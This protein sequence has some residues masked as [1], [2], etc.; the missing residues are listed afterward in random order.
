[1]G[2]L[3][4]ALVVGALFLM[5]S[6]LGIALPANA[7]PGPTPR[8]QYLVA[9]VLWRGVTDAERGFMDYL[10]EHGVPVRFV[11]FNC[12]NDKK[13]LPGY[14]AKVKALH[15]ALVYT[16]G[17]TVTSAVAGREGAVDPKRNITRTPIVFNIVA[18]PVGAG[19][20]RSMRS[21]GRNVTGVTHTVPLKSQ[22][23]TIMQLKAVHRLGVIYDPQEKNSVLAVQHLA[24]LQKTF[25][26]RVL[27]A[28]VHTSRGR[29]AAQSIGAAVQGLA[30]QKPDLIYLPSDSYLIAHANIVTGDINRLGIPS[31]SATEG[32]V[33][34]SGALMG[35]VTRY[36]NAGKFAG[37]KAWEILVKH[38]RPRDIPV[39]GLKRFTV[40]VNMDTARQLN[41]YPPVTLL[42][43]AEVVEKKRQVTTAH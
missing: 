32:P 18:D 41:F 13:R 35:L 7:A 9:M 12:N 3:G 37:F 2:Q 38:R 29:S 16:F 21:T 8:H 1:M 33:R 30:K 4:R 42:S 34:N 24:G 19:I 25:G 23:E 10:R 28:P 22:L 40:V 20:T 36:Y 11:Q 15:P 43:L 17:T 31:F 5:L 39:Q 27:R 14:I 26:Y 6:A